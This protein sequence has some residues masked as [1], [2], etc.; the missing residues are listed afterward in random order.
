MQLARTTAEQRSEIYT[1]VRSLIVPGFLSHAVSIGRARFVLRSLDQAD[2]LLL[3][4]RT[5]GLTQKDWKAWCV[6]TSIWMVNGSVLFED[7]TATY[8]L[9]ETLKEMPS[10]ALD[11]LYSALNGLMRR[12]NAASNII[13]AF[14]YENESRSLWKTQGTALIERRSW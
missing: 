11:K 7:E 9:Y 2:W 4:Y 14:L 13:E 6:A 5:E 3:E 10:A 12:V 8:R 1:D